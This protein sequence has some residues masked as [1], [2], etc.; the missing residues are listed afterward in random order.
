[1]FEGLAAAAIQLAFAVAGTLATF[2]ILAFTRLPERIVGLAVDQRMA[3]YQNRLDAEIERLKA[4]LHHGSDRGERSNQLEYEA[5]TSA[6][7]KFMAAHVA[8][9]TCVVRY[10]EFGDLDKMDDLQVDEYLRLTEF[11]EPQRKQIRD[12]KNKNDMYLKVERHRAINTAG[13]AIF[14]A[15]TVLQ[16]KAIFIPKELE[17]DFNSGLSTCARGWSIQKT[18]FA[19]GHWAEGGKETIKYM[20][21]APKIVQKLKERVRERILATYES[22]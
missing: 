22:T 19:H 4:R 15:R 2:T 21:D 17:A 20:E 7:E 11:S 8:T 6:W 3:T 9:Q 5:I 1:M 12:A 13:A 10:F 16:N 14:E 18:E